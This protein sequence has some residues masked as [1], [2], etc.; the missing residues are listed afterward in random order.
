MSTLCAQ[1]VRTRVRA[2]VAPSRA[3][4]GLWIRASVGGSPHLWRAL[5]KRALRLLP[6]RGCDQRRLE[7]VAVAIGASTSFAL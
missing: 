4:P 7:N 6:V 2:A 5:S 1:L 3:P